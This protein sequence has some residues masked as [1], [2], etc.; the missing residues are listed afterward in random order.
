[1]ACKRLSVRIRAEGAP[2]IETLLALKYGRWRVVGGLIGG[3]PPFQR[4][5]VQAIVHIFISQP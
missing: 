2:G 1:M 5:Q 4:P 3:G